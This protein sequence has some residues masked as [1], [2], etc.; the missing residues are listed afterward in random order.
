[1]TNQIAKM[2]KDKRE[3]LSTLV[4]S[5]IPDIKAVYVEKDMSHDI[6]TLM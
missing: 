1:M 3:E 4:N 2:P 5:F 6:A